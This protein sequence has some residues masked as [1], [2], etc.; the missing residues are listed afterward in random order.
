MA[1]LTREGGVF[2]HRLIMFLLEA[3]ELPQHYPHQIH[4]SWLGPKGFLVPGLGMNT[5]PSLP[6]INSLL[7]VCSLLLPLRERCLATPHEPARPPPLPPIGVPWWA[8]VSP[9]PEQGWRMV[10]S[11]Q[12]VP[13]IFPDPLVVSGP[14]ACLGS[15]PFNAG[16]LPCGLPCLGSLNLMR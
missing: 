11:S 13:D 9:G 5:E 4:F 8:S 14:T 15:S 6:K 2:P 10:L 12:A 3:V 1:L 7:A 16:T